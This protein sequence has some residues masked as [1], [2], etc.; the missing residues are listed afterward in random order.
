LAGSVD[1]ATAYA[2]AMLMTL[3]F[4][5]VPFLALSALVWRLPE[6]E[7]GGRAAPKPVL[8]E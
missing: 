6:P 1:P 8:A 3:L 4:V 5:P 7:L 2:H